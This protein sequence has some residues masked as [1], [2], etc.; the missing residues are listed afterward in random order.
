MINETIILLTYYFNQE[1]RSH[2]L[3]KNIMENYSGCYLPFDLYLYEPLQRIFSK[4]ILYDYL[5]RTAE[6]GVK[7]VNEEIIELVRRENAK[8][9]LWTSFYYD[10]QQSTLDIIRKEGTVVVGWFFDDEW[11]FDEYSKWWIPY[12]DYCVT[13]A[14][15]VVP[16][17]R[18]LGAQVIQTIPNTG[19]AI[20]RDWSSIE[21]RYDVSFVG[22]R[23]YADREQ[24]INELGDRNIPIHLFGEGWGGYIPFE[25]MIDIFKYSKINLNFSKDWRLGKLQIKGRIFQVCMADGFLLTEYVPGIEKYFKIDKEIVCFHDTKE[26]I[27]KI[28]YYLEH[29]E[30]RRAIAQAGWKRATGEYTSFHMVS[31]VFNEIEKHIVANDKESNPHLQKLKMP[32]RIRRIPAQYHF[33]WGRTFLEE[34]YKGLWK[35]ELALSISYNPFNIKAWGYYIIGFSPYSVRLTLFRLYRILYSRLRSI[36]YLRRIKQYFTKRLFHR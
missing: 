36:P 28:N 30:E 6:I 9:V 4:A 24:Y 23:F 12:L 17:Y 22:S 35:D 13:N 19:R 18:E 1:D 31:K 7:A 33:Q 25:E 2:R 14:I 8:Y 15:E 27:D 20:N 29:D 34:N 32:M 21:E 26:M 5:M 3:L 10:I 16:K 11:R